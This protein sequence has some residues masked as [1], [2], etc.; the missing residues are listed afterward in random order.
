MPEASPDIQ[1]QAGYELGHAL[2]AQDRCAEA[3]AAFVAAKEIQRPHA[4][5]FESRVAGTHASDAVG[6]ETCRRPKSFGAGR[7]RRP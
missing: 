7:R 4:Q 3:Y 5:A 1:C 6:G 2:D